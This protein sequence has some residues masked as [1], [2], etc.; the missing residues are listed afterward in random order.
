MF[1]F[2]GKHDTAKTACAYGMPNVTKV[3]IRWPSEQPV[4]LQPL[5]AI[6]RPP[7]IMLRPVVKQPSP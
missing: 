6:L 7:R 1:A 4:I 2:V 5:V 3:I